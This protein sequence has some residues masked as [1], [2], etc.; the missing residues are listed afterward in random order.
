MGRSRR[1]LR[2]LCWVRQ[3]RLCHEPRD[4]LR[5]AVDFERGCVKEATVEEGLETGLVEQMGGLVD[6]CAHVGVFEPGKDQTRNVSK[7]DAH[8]HSSH[9]ISP[10]A[11]SFHSSD[12]L[13]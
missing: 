5:T 2:R 9:L 6:G 4:C 12:L 11:K 8:Q 1:V 7:S 13:M 3:Q 10:L